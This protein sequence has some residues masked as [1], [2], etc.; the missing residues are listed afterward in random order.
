MENINYLTLK[1][2]TLLFF[3]FC[4]SISFFYSQDKK[5]ESLYTGENLYIE[6]PYPA[7]SVISDKTMKLES[8]LI[9][10][11]APWNQGQIVTFKVLPGGTLSRQISI[12]G[13]SIPTLEITYVS[14][15]GNNEPV[16]TD[17]RKIQNLIT[18][19][20]LTKHS[21]IDNILW[22]VGQYKN[23]YI[24]DQDS[25]AKKVQVKQFS[26]L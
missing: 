22:I 14:K 23:I 4:F 26:S 8:Y 3:L 12:A 11:G 19:E 17:K 1:M 2:K 5:P 20:E 9:E 7:Q 10:I 6:I 21:T 15:Q 16:K 13:R 24:I 25:K 18:Y